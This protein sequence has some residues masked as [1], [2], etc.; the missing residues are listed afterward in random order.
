MLKRDKEKVIILERKKKS[1][2]SC[3][4]RLAWACS[5]ESDY[6]GS[7]VIPDCLPHASTVLLNLQV[8]VLV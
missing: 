7:V 4:I 5:T 6:C 8:C 3:T 1:P 2:F